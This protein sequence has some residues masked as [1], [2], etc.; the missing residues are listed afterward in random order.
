MVPRLSC[1][2]SL[3]AVF[4]LTACI[5]TYD[6]VSDFDPAVD[7]TKY[8]TFSFMPERL[9]V[10]GPLTQAT[11]LYP[12]LEQGLRAASLAN[13]EK[14]GF[15]YV[16]D[17]EQA[18]FVVAYTFG[19]RAAMQG[20][21]YPSDFGRARGWGRT[22]YGN[23]QDT[24]FEQGILALDIYDVDARALVYHSHAFKT[25]TGEEQGDKRLLKAIVE[26]L[27]MPFPPE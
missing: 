3:V 8:A 1:A 25:L 11:N 12:N 16:E 22:W 7:F 18:D 24:N 9:L 27:Y 6:A 23:F 26:R 19:S 15:R 5:T 17:F 20:N 10:L 21:L 14:K 2:V 4:L 13:L